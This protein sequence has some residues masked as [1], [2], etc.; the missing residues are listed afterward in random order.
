MFL[1]DFFSILFLIIDVLLD[2]VVVVVVVVEVVVVLNK[3][4]VTLEVLSDSIKLSF[5]PKNGL[6][7]NAILFL[8][9]SSWMKYNE[10]RK[11]KKRRTWMAFHGYP[12]VII[13]ILMN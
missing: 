11:Q 10:E 4:G 9:I 8:I 6:R 12:C 1:P 13:I 7:P 5:L 3:V 2:W